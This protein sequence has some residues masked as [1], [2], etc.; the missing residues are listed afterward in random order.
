MKLKVETT[1]FMKKNSICNE[2]EDNKL[3]SIFLKL[4][5]TYKLNILCNKIHTFKLKN[6]CLKTQSITSCYYYLIFWRKNMMK[7]CRAHALHRCIVGNNY[8]VTIDQKLVLNSI[9]RSLCKQNIL[10]RPKSKYLFQ[11]L[12]HDYCWL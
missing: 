5:D 4:F 9:T 3:P 8:Q 6:S 12:L 1:L 7:C 11:K 10:M 2:K